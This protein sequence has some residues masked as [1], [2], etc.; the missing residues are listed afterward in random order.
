MNKKYWITR[1]IFSFVLMTL[2][3][4]QNVEGAGRV[5]NAVKRVFGKGG[6][7]V[8]NV[9][10]LPDNVIPGTA[11]RTASAAEVA[12]A[13]VSKAAS[14]APEVPVIPSNSSINSLKG[15]KSELANTPLLTRA[16]GPTPGVGRKSVAD[17][18]YME[19]GPLKTEP[20]YDAPFAHPK[21]ISKQTGSQGDNIYISVESS[22]PIKT[23]KQAEARDAADVQINASISARNSIVRN[24][25]TPPPVFGNPPVDVPAPRNVS[26]ASSGTLSL[27]SIEKGSLSKVDALKAWVSPRKIADGVSNKLG[28]AGYKDVAEQAATLKSVSKRQIE[29]KAALDDKQA[30]VIA[31]NVITSKGQVKFTKVSGDDLPGPGSTNVKAS[32]KENGEIDITYNTKDGTPKKTTIKSDEDMPVQKTVREDGSIA[33]HTPLTANEKATHFADRI[34][35]GEVLSVSKTGKVT[36]G[37]GTL[38]IGKFSK[39]ELTEESIA[40]TQRQAGNAEKLRLENAG[41]LMKTTRA[42]GSGF[43]WV[44]GKIKGAFGMISAL[45]LQ[46]V[47][48]TVPS[49]ILQMQAQKHQREALAKTVSDIQKFGDLYIQIPPALINEFDAVSS[50]FIYLEIPDANKRDEGYFTEDVLN[51]GNYYAVYAGDYVDWASAYIGGPGFGGKMVHLNSGWCFI[52]GGVSLDNSRPMFP[53]RPLQTAATSNSTVEAAVNG[54]ASGAGANTTNVKPSIF[55]EVTGLGSPLKRS[56][57]EFPKEMKDLFTTAVEEQKTSLAGVS[58]YRTPPPLFIK[59]ISTARTKQTLPNFG[60]VSLRQMQGTG[61]LNRLL[62]P[63]IPWDDP[64][65]QPLYKALAKLGDAQLAY[66]AVSASLKSNAGAEQ[67]KAAS[68]AIINAANAVSALVVNMQGHVGLVAEENVLLYNIYVYEISTDPSDVKTPSLN[69]LLQNKKST[70]IPVAEY[71]VCLDQGGNIV[72]LMIPAVV[73]KGS[74]HTVDYVYNDSITYLSSLTTG[75]T[76]LSNGTGQL[77]SPLML[78][79]KVTPDTTF[80]TNSVNAIITALA[81]VAKSSPLIT[82]ALAQIVDMANYATNA[83]VAGPFVLSNGY[84]F[85]LV[86]LPAIAGAETSNNTAVLDATIAAMGD[87]FSGVSAWSGAAYAAAPASLKASCLANAYIYKVSIPGVNGSP[88]LGALSYKNAQGVVVDIP[89]YVIAVTP[90]PNKTQTIL[91]LGLSSITGTPL[92]ANTQFLISLI[93]GCIYD[94]NY[95]LL[96]PSLTTKVIDRSYTSYLPTDGDLGSQINQLNASTKN[97]PTI[98]STITD[99]TTGQQVAADLPYLQASLATAYMPTAF[100]PNNIIFVNPADKQTYQTNLAALATAQAAQIAAAGAVNKALGA[101]PSAP[102]PKAVLDM[103]NASIAS[104]S[105]FVADFAKIPGVSAGL[106]QSTKTAL[107]AYRGATNQYTTAL[108]KYT[109]FKN[110]VDSGGLTKAPFTGKT[111]TAGPNEQLQIPPLYFVFFSNFSY[112]TDGG[113]TPLP[114]PSSASLGT[115]VNLTWVNTKASTNSTPIAIVNSD[116]SITP[117]P[118]ANVLPNTFLGFDPSDQ[119]NYYASAAGVTGFP[120][121]LSTYFQWAASASSAYWAQSALVGPFNFTTSSIAQSDKAGANQNNVFIT[122]TSRA[123]VANGNFFYSA[124]GFDTSDVFVVGH[125]KDTSTPVTQISDLQ[126]LGKPFVNPGGPNWYMVNMSTGYVYTPYATDAIITGTNA[127]PATDGQNGS[128]VIYCQDA[129][130]APVNVCVPGA[131]STAKWWTLVQAG[132]ANSIGG[133]QIVVPLRFNTADV[134][135][136]VLKNTVVNGRQ[137]TLKDMTQSLQQLLAN[138]Q[139]VGKQVAAQNLYPLYF[140]NQFTLRLRQDQIDNGTYIYAVTNKGESYLGG[141]DYLVACNITY[142]DS[143][144]PVDLAIVPSP[145]SANTTSMISL[146]SGTVYSSELGTIPEWYVAINGYDITETPGAIEQSLPKLALDLSASINNLNAVYIAQKKAAKAA[147]KSTTLPPLDLT[148]LKPFT[149]DTASPF[150]NFYSSTAS[151]KTKYYMKSQDVGVY[152]VPATDGTF[153]VSTGIITTYFDFK[154]TATS[155]EQDQTTDYGITYTVNAKTNIASPTGTLAGFSLQSMRSHNGVYVGPDG[156]QVLGVPVADLYLPKGD[157]EATLIPAFGQSGEY[158]NY[159]PQYGVINDTTN[160]L[161]YTYYQNAAINGFFAGV[162]DQGVRVTDPT[163]ATS[164][165][166]RK[167]DK[168]V[169]LLTGDA[170]DVTGAA[171]PQDVTMAFKHLRP[172]VNIQTIPGIKAAKL[173]L[174]ALQAAKPVTTGTGTATDSLYFSADTGKYYYKVVTFGPA[175]DTNGNT[176]NDSNGKG[177]V[178]EITRYFDFN[179]SKTLAKPTTD[180]EMGIWY[181]VSTTPTVAVPIDNTWVD[182]ET[183]LDM[184]YLTDIRN[185]YGVMVA[186]NGAQTLTTPITQGVDYRRTL[187]VWGNQSM[188]DDEYSLNAMYHNG[189]EY[190]YYNYVPFSRL[191]KFTNRDNSTLYYYGYAPQKGQTVESTSQV[192]VTTIDIASGTQTI[193]LLNS[194]ILMGDAVQTAMAAGYLA[195]ATQYDLVAGS[196]SI[197]VEETMLTPKTY[198]ILYDINEYLEIL[199]NITYQTAWKKSPSDTSDIASLQAIGNM[200]TKGTPFV[201]TVIGGRPQ[202]DQV[203]PTITG[204]APYIAGI[205]NPQTSALLALVVN[206]PNVETGD[207]SVQECIAPAIINQSSLPLPGT[208]VSY[209]SLVNTQV[210]AMTSNYPVIPNPVTGAP[211]NQGSYI[212]IQSDSTNEY[213]YRYMTESV[214]DYALG[215]ITTTVNIVANSDGSSTLAGSFSTADLVGISGISGA[216][217]SNIFFVS[218]PEQ[219]VLYKVPTVAQ[220]QKYYGSDTTM[221]TNDAGNSI[222]AYQNFA[223]SVGACPVGSYIDYETGIIFTVSATDPKVFYPIGTSLTPEGLALVREQFDG[224]V[225]QW[226]NGV[227]VLL[228]ADQAAQQRSTIT[229]STIGSAASKVASSQKVGTASPVVTKITTKRAAAPTPEPV[230]VRAV[231]PAVIAPTKVVARKA[232]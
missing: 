69:F 145:I 1:I 136:A 113:A 212:T 213:L 196:D 232:K 86:P 220:A 163:F 110:L 177:I 133:N 104:G 51:N 43:K 150:Y 6:T 180:T 108:S 87:I 193:A 84:Q 4:F 188:F 28:T 128:R 165:I 159:F 175:V 182:D 19:L 132:R 210:F 200:L 105:S 227:P 187:F 134:L 78:P 130:G 71:V 5:A 158:M 214:S 117:I 224:A 174:A 225:V 198:T 88:M 80:A 183:D 226:N 18:D 162:E 149:T 58:G 164:S 127:V 191:Y 106:A 64:D 121:L 36:M 181:Q 99:P 115:N 24:A 168:F 96:A 197:T 190:S 61:F 194:S 68:D 49:T 92:P 37:Q 62:S 186:A 203:P 16:D 25:E 33:E 73:K 142:D 29:A 34:N 205:L 47:A 219:R 211:L 178:T 7:V 103:Y 35:R 166:V 167:Q 40:V 123:D 91:P 131:A 2:G 94:V 31:D 57:T 160:N 56:S 30:T 171:M 141:T 101:N 231:D 144:Y 89:D 223:Q 230:A 228:G 38:K 23:P 70:Q 82:A 161:N 9:G 72:P 76:Y 151:G 98:K 172:R 60:N 8:D 21:S 114:V 138:V 27:R 85:D 65:S 229:P 209:F 66:N 22:S 204:G 90:S 153:T 155:F 217:A 140:N 192:Q 67:L 20:I 185:Y 45:L 195:Y 116:T 118:L 215:A 207:Y 12:A 201:A 202:G 152:A 42:I 189:T 109:T 125:T 15:L 199:P 176:V 120:S 156:T 102:I 169:N 111:V 54:M 135:T 46:T 83:A 139:A 129:S 81:A 221:Y 146:V 184:Q 11:G 126:D 173:P 95:N 48:F 143:G 97:W 208:L 124:T 10:S 39:G 55:N 148:K 41:K 119:T 3:L 107:D 77:G 112:T 147:A 93:T 179:A 50:R 59:A 79:D 17:G 26:D 75:L 32:P 53:L 44:G 100:N 216:M 122:A 14:A 222:S 218:S 52:G 74:S 206:G 157:S 154:A 137:G 13:R 63:N 170:Y